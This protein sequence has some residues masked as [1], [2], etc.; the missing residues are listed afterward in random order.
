MC[1]LSTRVVIFVFVYIYIY[2]QIHIYIYSIYIYIYIYRTC[3]GKQWG[4]GTWADRGALLEVSWGSNRE[5]RT[6]Y[7]GLVGGGGA[8]VFDGVQ[9][10]AGRCCQ[11][12]VH[13]FAEVAKIKKVVAHG[14][15]KASTV[16]CFSVCNQNNQIEP[17]AKDGKR[18]QQVAGFLDA[19]GNLWPPG[20]GRRRKRTAAAPK[21]R[22][23]GHS[24]A[25]TVR[26]QA[27]V[28][29]M[30]SERQQVCCHRSLSTGRPWALQGTWHEL[31][32]SRRWRQG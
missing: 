6:R 2:I 12:G 27:G 25:S 15:E 11:V 1:T 20:A 8:Q 16:S 31:Q 14:P 3:V 23:R 19:E 30:H 5:G 29:E 28:R 10:R 17:R 7:G 4:A 18:G 9:Q 13:A 24:L 22:R 26:E 21:N 32:V